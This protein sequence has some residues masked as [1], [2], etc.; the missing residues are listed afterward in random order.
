M[1]GCSAATRALGCS[2]LL[3]VCVSPGA[4]ASAQVEGGAVGVTSGSGGAHQGVVAAA[5]T[6]A[7]A[8]VL[9]MQPPPGAARQ[10]AH[11]RPAWPTP[12]A[13]GVDPTSIAPSNPPTAAESLPAGPG[14]PLA[15]P[16]DL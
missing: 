10:L 5:Q 6:G 9:S 3:A 14:A 7:V 15:A 2:L 12:V 11:R 13:P 16:G 4:P 1:S 8:R